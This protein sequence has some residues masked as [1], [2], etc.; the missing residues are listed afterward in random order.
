MDADVLVDV[1]I[2]SCEVGLRKPD[3]E[4]FE[5]TAERLGVPPS[6]CVMIDD[7]AWNLTGAAAT[8]NG[9]FPCHRSGNGLPQTSANSSPSDHGQHCGRTLLRSRVLVTHH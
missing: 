7:F 1:V 4:I 6:A 3:P 8:G 9:G 2:D 5:L